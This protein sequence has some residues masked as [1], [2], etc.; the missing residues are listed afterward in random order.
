LIK[1][2]LM[3]MGTALLLT[4]CLSAFAGTSGL[5]FNVSATG[6]PAEINITL[7][8]NGQAALSCQNYTAKGLTLAIAPAIPNHVYPSVG[9]KI[10]TPNYQ[11]AK[12]GID[13]T[14]S[15]NGYCLFSLSSAQNKVLSILVDGPLSITPAS[16]PAATLDG[17]L[18][19]QLI[20]ASG[21]LAP[22]TY[23]I[24]AGALPS[25]LSLNQS[26]GLLSGIATTN[27]T[28]YFTITATDS[29]TN[30][31]SHDYTLVVSGPLPITPTT[32]P[33]ARLNAG[34]NQTVT[35][36]GGIAPYTY[37]ISSGALPPGLSLAQSTGVISGTPTTDSTYGFTITAVDSM[38]NTG[39]LAYTLVVSGPLSITP[40]SL[41]AGTLNTAYTQTVTASGGTAPYTY[42]ISYGS[43]P[44]G[45][46]LNSST[47]V[48]SGTPIT[49]GTY[50][51][52]LTAF[53]LNGLRGSI[54]YSIVV[55]GL[56]LSPTTLPGA[57][58]NTAYSETITASDG[59]SP[60]TYTVTSGAL[61]TGLSLD[62]STGV[63]SGTPTTVNTYN[64]TITAN[65]SIYSTASQAYTFVVSGPLSLSPSSL[66]PTAIGNTTYTQ[67]IT[68]SSGVA[69]YTY[70]ITFSSLPVGL[71]LNT[72]TGIISGIP[73]VN[74]TSIFT[75]TAT[76]SLSNTGAK[77]YVLAVRGLII[78][79]STLPAAPINNEYNQTITTSGGIAPYSYTISSGSLPPGLS[80]NETTGVISG[81]PT[82][83]NTYN[84]TITATDSAAHTGSMDYSLTTLVGQI[85]E[86]AQACSTQANP[87]TINGINLN[88]L[89]D[90]NT[91][92][93]AIYCTGSS[94]CNINTHSITPNGPIASTSV[95]I[96]NGYPG[97][98][99]C[100]FTICP[101]SV[102][103]YNAL[104]CTNIYTGS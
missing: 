28:Y 39:A 68:A 103:S 86:F 3:S 19:N 95:G 31:G 21:G 50:N 91:S 44:T 56:V 47:G 11:L 65:D 52:T 45:L 1:R 63:I 55:T 37:T 40:S 9:I 41:P 93:R 84:F 59:V 70:S 34:Y 24:T 4:L 74:G 23:A 54:P 29:L 98:G 51:L 67:T 13:C 30:T 101:S 66:L 90:T 82:T 8:L 17:F 46:S 15:S 27:D 77:G 73:T 81:I 20:T 18:Y 62:S 88:W 60:Y 85:T 100:S 89:G 92:Y 22:Y 64:F 75:I 94:T 36:S 72:S 7:C 57:T 79:P 5:L 69:P 61:P 76:D 10:H 38:S 6:T 58:L 71:T 25:G 99:P 97:S 42:S 87:W 49:D 35:A 48:I 53:D 104:L 16:L 43:L 78:S 80:L 12:I 26:T 2:L 14:S 96:A 83:A 32:L 102:T 33:S